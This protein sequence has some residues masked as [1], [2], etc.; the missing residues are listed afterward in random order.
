MIDE[1]NPALSADEWDVHHRYRDRPLSQISY[2][3]LSSGKTIVVV[4]SD[5]GRAVLEDPE[6]MVAAV[7]IANA[8]LP[9]DSPYKIQ[10]G[11]V[12]A[13]RRAAKLLSTAPA[14][15][16]Q[17]IELANALSALLPPEVA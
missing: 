1:L 11:H 2:S 17:L 13:L 10:G 12:A 16:D 4:I 6:A 8:A 3:Q 9:D 7:A 14:T 5:D 15:A